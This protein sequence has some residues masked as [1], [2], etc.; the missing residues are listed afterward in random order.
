MSRAASRH[1]QRLEE[2]IRGA[3]HRAAKSKRKRK[4]WPWPVLAE[5]Y[6]AAC[7][8][9][10]FVGGPH[11]RGRLTMTLEGKCS[12]H[13]GHNGNPTILVGKYGSLD[14]TAESS[15]TVWQPPFDYPTEASKTFR[16]RGDKAQ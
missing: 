9:R 4:S 16:K 10:I 8:P 6:R 14:V 11:T 12:L 5:M 2:A 13:S 3:L 7:S 1:I 15:S